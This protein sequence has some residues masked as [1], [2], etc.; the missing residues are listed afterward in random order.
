MI[1]CPHILQ[2]HIRTPQLLVIGTFMDCVRS[3]LHLQKGNSCEFEVKILMNTDS[4]TLS[5]TPITSLHS[6]V[7][8]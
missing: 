4:S 8:N 2:S 3:S 6:M 1:Q 5:F 7:I